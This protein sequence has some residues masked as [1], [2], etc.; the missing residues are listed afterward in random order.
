MDPCRLW[1]FPGLK[2]IK[3]VRLSSISCLLQ[4]AVSG[5]PASYLDQFVPDSVDTEAEVALSTATTWSQDTS[6][7]RGETFILELAT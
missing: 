6:R 1:T 4:E 5:D 2:I 3:I 7:D